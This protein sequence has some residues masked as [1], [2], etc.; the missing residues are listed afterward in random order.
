MHVIPF[1]ISW[2]LSN[3]KGRLLRVSVYCS[4]DL[5]H[6]YRRAKK[7]FGWTEDVVITWYSWPLGDNDTLKSLTIFAIVNMPLINLVSG[8]EVYW[9]F[10]N[11][12]HIHTLTVGSKTYSD[13]YHLFT[14]SPVIT[15]HLIKLLHTLVC[16]WMW[17]CGFGHTLLLL[18]RSRN[19]VFFPLISEV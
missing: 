13:N 2:Y 15:L 18:Y 16:Q 6:S 1:L 19:N 7:V 4:M 12:D 9:H 17:L 3:E 10:E 14:L 5:G 11:F 8:D